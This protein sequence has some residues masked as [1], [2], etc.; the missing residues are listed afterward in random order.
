MHIDCDIYSSTKTVL[1]LTAGR[2]APGAVLVFDEFFNY[3]SFERHEYK[4]FFEFV[5]RFDVKYRFIGYSGQQVS[6]VIDAIQTS[7][8]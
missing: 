2:L 6:M 1:G 3:V 8:A 5:E 4:A 7:A